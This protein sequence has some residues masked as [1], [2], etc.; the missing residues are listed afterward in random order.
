MLCNPA[1]V[2][3]MPDLQTCWLLI[4]LRKKMAWVQRVKLCLPIVLLV[5]SLQLV[6]LGCIWANVGWVP[7]SLSFLK[8]CCRQ[9]VQSLFCSRETQTALPCWDDSKWRS[10]IWCSNCMA[11]CFLGSLLNLNRAGKYNTP[12]ELSETGDQLWPRC[13]LHP[14]RWSNQPSS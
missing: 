2:S 11:A 3:Q 13:A 10:E 8:A 7:L 5:R 1:G 14:R 9:M 12:E 6:S 4:P